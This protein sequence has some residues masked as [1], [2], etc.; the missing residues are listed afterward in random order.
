MEITTNKYDWEKYLIESQ[1]RLCEM[2]NNKE[3]GKTRAYPTEI[4][5]CDHL[6][7]NNSNEDIFFVH[8]DDLDTEPRIPEKLK[9]QFQSGFDIIAFNLKTNNFKRIQ[10]KYR[11]SCIFLE[12]TR[13]NS[14][15]NKDKNASGHVSYSSDEF[16]YLI[17]VKGNF[18]ST[19]DLS[20]DMLIFPKEALIDKINTNIL[21]NRVKKSIEKEYTERTK[22]MLIEIY[23]I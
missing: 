3:L 5:V 6:N 14:K 23:K 17:V 2:R 10:V 22:E 13:R 21:V 16:D 20:K 11:S 1:R 4:M 18:E 12:T 7:Q 8:N 19:C 9:T 15:K